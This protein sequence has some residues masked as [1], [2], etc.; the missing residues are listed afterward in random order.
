[1]PPSVCDEEMQ[2]ALP[3]AA[4]SSETIPLPP[5]APIT[6]LQA[7]IVRRTSNGE[8]FTG[9]G[10]SAEAL[11]AVLGEAAAAVVRVRGATAG[12][13][14][15]HPSLWVVVQRVAGIPA[16]AYR[17]DSTTWGLARVRRGDLGAELQV[18]ANLHNINL[19]LAAFTVYV[20]DWL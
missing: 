8:L 6:G 9:R 5:A 13:D 3:L 12:W 11:S 2:R 1:Y 20:A 18:H 16:G 15:P 14:L 17:C 7:A 10:V 4:A 19:D